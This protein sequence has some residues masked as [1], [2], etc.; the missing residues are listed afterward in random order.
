MPRPACGSNEDGRRS[1]S[2]D[3]FLTSLNDTLACGL[4]ASLLLF[5]VFVIL[6]NVEDQ[7][8]EP[9]QA[10]RIADDVSSTAT[11]GELANA[12]P[13]LLLRMRGPC[14]L[15]ETVMIKGTDFEKSMFADTR[16]GDEAYKTKCV[17]LLA[18]PDPEPSSG[19]EVISGG[20]SD[21]EVL[22]TAT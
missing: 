1:M 11:G 5:I 16:D 19:I 3:D 12:R 6:I 18:V 20:A 4:G 8:S 17:A 13:G 7:L 21:G 10:Q 22:L 15:I 14:K 9:G 2:D